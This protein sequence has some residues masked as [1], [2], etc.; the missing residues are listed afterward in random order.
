M[1]YRQNTS[2]LFRT[3]AIAPTYRPR[4]RGQWIPNPQNGRL[5]RWNGVKA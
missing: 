5:P 1:I 3:N 2:L 4:N